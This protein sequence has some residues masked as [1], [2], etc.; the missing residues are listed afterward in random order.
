MLD[1]LF[2]SQNVRRVTF[3]QNPLINL[4]LSHTLPLFLSLS[5]AF[6]LSRSL[7]LFISPILLSFSLSIYIYI[8][9]YIYIFFL[10]AY[11]STFTSLSYSIQSI[12]IFVTRFPSTNFYPSFSFICK[13][14]SRDHIS[15]KVHQFRIVNVH[16]FIYF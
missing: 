4:L 13:N 2:F 3:W 12:C 9:L 8:Y 10:T 16:L 11:L 1:W 5:L 14:N 15:K 7:S 6:S